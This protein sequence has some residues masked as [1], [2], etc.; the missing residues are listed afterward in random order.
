MN[1]FKHLHMIGEGSFGVVYLAEEVSSKSLV[2]IKK[3]KRRYSSWEECMNLREVRSLRKLRHPFIIKLR[4][5]FRE[6]NQL[7]LV[8][9]YMESN[10]FKFYSS[11][12]KEKGKSVPEHVIK[13]VIYQTLKGLA[14]LHEKGFFHRDLKPENLLV[15]SNNNIKIADF[16]LARE[17]RSM[18]PYTDYIS[19]R[20]YRAPEMLLKMSNYSHSVDIFAL[21]CIMAELYLGRPLFDGKSEMDQM[22]KIFNVLGEPGANWKEGK[23]LAEKLNIQLSGKKPKDLA[24]VVPSASLKGI[25]LLQEM[26]MLD[27]Y[28]RKSAEA[29]LSHPYFCEMK[30]E[31]MKN[32][33]DK[34]VKTK[35][36]PVKR[37]FEMNLITNNVN[38][39][40]KELSRRNMHK[41]IMLEEIL[42]EAVESKV[43]NSLIDNKSMTEEIEQ[44]INHHTEICN[45]PVSPIGRIKTELFKKKSPLKTLEE[46]PY[47]YYNSKAE[48]E[49]PCLKNM[50]KNSKQSKMSQ[51]NNFS[52]LSLKLSA[53]TTKPQKISNFRSSEKPEIKSNIDFENKENSEGFLPSYMCFMGAS[54]NQNSEFKFHF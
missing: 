23:L 7:H 2:A 17:I 41:N 24:K 25:D 35:K 1:R 6:D 47:Q 10:L 46:A 15:D 22:F 34:C 5:V 20:W 4:E 40:L 3:M 28:K 18:P 31:K 48:I 13:K 8:F 45:N 54:Q 44:I 50:Y 52:D 30:K 26:F 12:Y 14:Y 21:G 39:K 49:S 16:G 36:A 53:S 27:P 29:L 42:G 32:V 38:R 33:R 9:D 37:N 19:T 51:K 43:D 11:N